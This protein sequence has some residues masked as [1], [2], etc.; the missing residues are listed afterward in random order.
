MDEFVIESFQINIYHISITGILA[1][2][3]NRNM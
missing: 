1:G 2:S 3:G